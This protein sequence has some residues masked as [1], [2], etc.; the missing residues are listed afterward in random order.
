MG[1]RADEAIRNSAPPDV[2]AKA[3]AQDAAAAA[4]TQAEKDALAVQ[5]YKEVSGR[6]PQDSSDR[7]AV[8]IGAFWLAGAILFFSLVFAGVLLLNNKVVPDSVY[9]LATAGVSGVI[10]GIFGYAK[11]T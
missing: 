2:V 1:I 3:A 9:V 7:R 6:F 8:F 11:Q 5:L 4:P 10:G